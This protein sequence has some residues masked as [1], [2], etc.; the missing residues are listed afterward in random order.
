MR[1]LNLQTPNISRRG[2]QLRI[3]STTARTGMVSAASSREII[4]IAQE[5]VAN[6]H[7]SLL[8]CHHPLN[9]I[10][11]WHSLAKRTANWRHEPA[12]CAIPISVVPDPGERTRTRNCPVCAPKRHVRSFTAAARI[13]SGPKISWKAKG[14]GR[15]AG[16]L[17]SKR[18]LRVRVLSPQPRS[19]V[20]TS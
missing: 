10:Q 5:A 14:F 4:K 20:S 17:F 3:S 13:I 7:N 8:S 2:P 18:H 6:S 16:D 19:P 11:P 1:P 15:C 9:L 12:S